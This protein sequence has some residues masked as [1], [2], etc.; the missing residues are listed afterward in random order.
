[1]DKNLIVSDYMPELIK[2]SG[3]GLEALTS[4]LAEFVKLP[5]LITTSAYK[6]IS[7]SSHYNFDSFQVELENPRIANE[8]IFCCQLSAGN[9]HTKAMVKSIAPAGRI[10]GYIFLLIDDKITD[11]TR[12]KIIL[13][14]AA[15]L[16]APHL[17]SQLE[18]KQE[19]SK[20]KNA[21]LYDLLYGN[22]K[23]KEE[24][25]AQGEMW[26]WNFRQPHIAAIFML[27]E[28]EFQSPSSHFMDVFA[29]IVEG[30]FMSKYYKHPATIARMNEM[31]V[32]IP[33]IT[34]NFIH[35]K[36]EIENFISGIFSQMENTELK[37]LVV[38]GV[39]QVYSDASELFR[40][41]QE[42]KVS[43]EMGKLLDIP[44]PFFA[45]LGLERI[46]YKHDLQDLKEYYMHV[47]G[48]LRKQDDPDNSLIDLL[49]N[50]ADNQFDVKKTAKATFLHP[51]T[52]RYRLNKIENILGKSLAES[53]TRLNIVAAL[54]I[55]RLHDI[56]QELE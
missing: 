14:Y 49:E 18:L 29:R 23:R 22:L 56:E 42:A 33:L 8:Q 4:T 24:I 53:E 55:R 44:I 10:I 46:L 37:G 47:L 1:M 31:V 7:A 13:D 54:K 3:Q 40:S 39:G 9:F 48:D 17:Q 25:I 41:Y 32:I 43:F 20:F 19:Q 11:F 12:Y 45:D 51:N 6:I 27:P 5:V 34:D 28:L 50:F 21:F 26:G 30:A 52:L 35:Q 36:T 38:C 2:S 16:Y 15:S